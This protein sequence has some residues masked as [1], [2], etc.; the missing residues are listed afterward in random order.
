[1]S[2]SSLGLD[3]FAVPTAHCFAG[4]RAVSRLSLTQQNSAGFG[5]GPLSGSVSGQLDVLPPGVPQLPPGQSSSEV[6]FLDLNGDG[7]P[8]VAGNGRV[9]YTT[10]T[11]GLEAHNRSVPALGSVRTSESGAFNAGVGGNA[12]EVKANARAE[13]D[14]SSKGA[15][16]E[17]KSGSQMV[18][19]GLAGSLG[20]GNSDARTDLLDVNGDGLPDRISYAGSQLMVA[21]NLGYGFAQ[22]EPWGDAAINDG[23]SLSL[24][25]S[26]GFNTGIYDF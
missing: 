17:N 4:R 18:S 8:D 2:S 10:P 25:A 23:D 9:Q 3:Y 5:V 14:T 20:G 13:V 11:G 26:L 16:R 22:A 24:G 7:F 6:D 1:M 19:L 15:P 21:L 12:A